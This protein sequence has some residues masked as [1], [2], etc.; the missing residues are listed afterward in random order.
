MPEAEKVDEEIVDTERFFLD[1]AWLDLRRC[2][3]LG[4]ELEAAEWAL[5]HAIEGRVVN[6]FYPH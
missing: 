3:V 1:E 5:R 6:L 4:G 2:Y